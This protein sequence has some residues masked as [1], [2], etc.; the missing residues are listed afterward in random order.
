MLFI[1]GIV[2]EPDPADSLISRACMAKYLLRLMATDFSETYY[3]TSWETDLEHHLWDAAH[4]ISVE[5]AFGTCTLEKDE[6]KLILEFATLANGWWVYE[7][8]TQP[9]GHGPVFIPM[10]RWKQILAEKEKK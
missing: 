7:D 4:G 5:A 9:V 3:F 1:P 8:E 10:D 6:Q 2:P